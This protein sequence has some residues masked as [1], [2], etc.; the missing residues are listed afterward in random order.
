MQT[1]ILSGVLTENCEKRTDK[2]GHEYVRFRLACEDPDLSGKKT[3]TI[4]R[5]YTYNLLFDNLRK[6][7]LL[8]LSGSLVINK[9]R[10]SIN[11]DVKVQNITKG[12]KQS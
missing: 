2:N 12:F 9:Y 8:F 5:C 7:D 6:D 10:D 3:T 11:L 4:Y 1:V